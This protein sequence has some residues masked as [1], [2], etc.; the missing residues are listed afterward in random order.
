M[1]NTPLWELI[2]LGDWKRP[3]SIHCPGTICGQETF[4]ENV[5][6]NRGTK[7]CGN[8]TAYGQQ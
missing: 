4:E 3:P 7:F 6:R 5:L 1:I 8:E 2:R